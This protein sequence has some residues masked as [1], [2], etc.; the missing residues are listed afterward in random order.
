MNKKQLAVTCMLMFLMGVLFV[1]QSIFQEKFKTIVLINNNISGFQ[2]YSSNKKE[3]EFVL[4]IQWETL[5]QNFPGNYIIYNNNFFDNN[6]GIYGYL[7]VIN[8]SDDEEKLIQFDKDYIKN[9]VRNYK[10]EKF[11]GKKY[12]GI[13]VS[14]TSGEIESKEII[15]KIYYIRTNDDRMVKM[16][17]K[18][19]SDLFKESYE[20][21]FKSLV[22]SIK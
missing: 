8:F 13:K 15:N 21:I 11:N 22:D 7:Q 4:P 5:V 10:E 16:A 20:Q 1:G 14:Y 19:K 12:K 17:F 18:V 6:S 3:V 9:K 2:E